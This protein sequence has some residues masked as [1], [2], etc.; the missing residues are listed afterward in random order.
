MYG[1]ENDPEA[2]SVRVPDEDDHG[3]EYAEAFYPEWDGSLPERRSTLDRRSPTTHRT[4]RDM[5]ARIGRGR[6]LEDARA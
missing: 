2:F 6:R 1:S 4:I 5:T 3:R